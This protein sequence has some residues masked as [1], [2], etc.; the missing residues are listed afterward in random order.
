[1]HT[2]HLHCRDITGMI[3]DY[4]EDVLFPKED[5]RFEAH[6][7][8][9]GGCPLYLEQ[10]RATVRLLRSLGQAEPAPA[11]VTR[12]AFLDRLLGRRARAFVRAWALARP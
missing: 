9:C 12:P 4:L 10:M 3:T 7:R 8:A 6:L 11:P 5:A 2:E 1:M